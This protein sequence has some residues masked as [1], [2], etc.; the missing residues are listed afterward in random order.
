MENLRKIAEDIRAELDT[1]NAGREQALTIS[2]EVIRLSANAI[3][4]VHRDEFD[5]ARQLMDVARRKVEETRG[6]LRDQLDIYYA[7]YVQDAQ[8]EYAESELTRALVLDQPLPSHEELGVECAAYLNGLGEAIG[9][10]R[11]RVLDIIRKGELARGEKLLQVM[12]DAYY[13]LVTYDYP[14]AITSGL[15]RTTD[16]VRGV[17]ERTRGDLT[18][19]IR[20]RELEQAIETAIGRLDSGNSAE[21]E[22]G[23]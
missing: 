21:A 23:D 13:M 3:R 15:R 16:M 5:E 9:E 20:Q 7:G 11:R 22:G 6:I 1:K 12:D 10:C 19:T 4:A 17:L 2:R 14:D 18:V 8:K